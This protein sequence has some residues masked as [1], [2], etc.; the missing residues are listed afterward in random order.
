MFGRLSAFRAIS[1]IKNM[2]YG[3]EKIFVETA[4]EVEEI[5]GDE[6]SDGIANAADEQALVWLQA[7]KEGEGNFTEE[8]ITELQKMSTSELKKDEVRRS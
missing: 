3:A 7:I 1:Q 5:L 2:E 6:I 8:F 4:D